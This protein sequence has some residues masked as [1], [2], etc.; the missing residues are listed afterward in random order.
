MAIERRLRETYYHCYRISCT[1][2][3]RRIFTLVIAVAMVTALVVG[4]GALAQTASAPSI[5]GAVAFADTDTAFSG[6]TSIE[7]RF[8]AAID[9]SSLSPGEIEVQLRDGTN[10]SASGVGAGAAKN[11]SQ[12]IV[13]V[14]DRS[15]S[16]IDAI[17]FDDSASVNTS[18]GTSYNGSDIESISVTRATTTVTEGDSYQDRPAFRGET[19]ALV[20]NTAS[21][22]LLIRSAAD[23]SLLEIRQVPDS[24]QVHAFD[25]A[26]LED[27]AY[28]IGFD[29]DTGSTDDRLL[30]LIE[31]ELD[32]QVHPNR[33][34]DDA[35][36]TDTENV[37]G[38]VS[39]N[40]VN[41][42]L[43]VAVL[44]GDDE[45]RSTQVLTNGTG[46]A[47]FSFAPIRLDEADD[48]FT[49]VARHE[50]SQ[51]RA[52]ERIKVSQVEYAAG[53]D[54][55]GIVEERGDVV[56]IPVVMSPDVGDKVAIDRA[57]VSIGGPDVAYQ[58]NVTV[59]DWNDD[60]E[61][62]LRWN[63]YLAD[64]AGG[65][66][67]FSVE[68][69]D[70]DERDDAVTVD[71][72]TSD[73]EGGPDDVLDG[74]T[75]EITV[76]S[77]AQSANASANASGT[78]FLTERETTALNVS[79]APDDAAIPL[80]SLEEIQEA[81]ENGE[82]TR[83]DTVANGDRVVFDIAASGVGGAIESNESANETVRFE[84]FLREAASMR[85]V[86][87]NPVPNTEP[88]VL[89]VNASSIDTVAVQETN[90]TY[91]VVVDLDATQVTRDLNGNDVPDSGEPTVA[92]TDED[93]FETTFE[94][95]ENDG[96]LADRPQNVSVSWVYQTPTAEIE[97]TIVDSDRVAVVEPEPGQTITGTSNVAPGTELTVRVRGDADD[98]AILDQR[99]VHVVENGRFSAEFSFA[100]APEDAPVTISV[101]RGGE[102]LATADGL[103]RADSTNSNAGSTETERE[104]S[105]STTE[106]RN[107]PNLTAEGGYRA[108]FVGATSTLERTTTSSTPSSPSS[109]EPGLLPI[110][111]AV[112]VLAV[113]AGVAAWL[114]RR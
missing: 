77:G 75:Y 3:D 13:A 25:T 27:D 49:V 78:V 20:G 70:D 68:R 21:E 113:A 65:A 45:I 51:T 47:S 85:T 60:Q 91:F 83:T 106:T 28:A 1:N 39:T 92:L 56:E 29:G 40:R 95:T 114:R 34:V 67:E 110:G 11:D 52:I 101:R 59:S 2:V 44:D 7:V 16:S 19:V 93:Q 62:V 112:V 12:F 32:V 100:G 9:E 61:V 97:Q 24:G 50:P 81:T 43:S 53:F 76:R 109:T 54:T 105:E 102:E 63:T 99:S 35:T 17:G 72:V 84:Q 15:V 90:D 66:D 5:T 73:V 88:K 55:L 86:Q 8:D 6:N 71:D 18:D 10:T 41:Q 22:E 46:E 42:Q 64:G 96:G 98:W 48:H 58:A 33:N 4:P 38:T 31:Y 69:T 111:T 80:E 57:T 26:D 87:T 79:V 14:G 37:T 74:G 89:A 104:A 30:E 23:G 94:I 108:E 36:V 107:N 103:V 82:L